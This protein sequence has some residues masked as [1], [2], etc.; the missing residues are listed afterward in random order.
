MDYLIG[1]EA[2][3]RGDPI[4]NSGAAPSLSNVCG[5]N[6]VLSG[7]AELDGIHPHPVTNVGE[8]VREGHG[9]TYGSTLIIF[10]MSLIPRIVSLHESQPFDGS[11]QRHHE[12]SPVG[13][14]NV[15]RHG[16]AKVSAI[17]M[18]FSVGSWLHCECLLRQR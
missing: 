15:C 5:G 17:Y 2:K 8:T 13:D 6:L 18:R 4:Q 3:R 14:L 10:S 11:S 12:E 7:D 9:N 1:K 16:F